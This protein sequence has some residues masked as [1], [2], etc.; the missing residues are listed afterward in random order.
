MPAFEKLFNEV[1]DTIPH[2]AE[3]ELKEFADEAGEIMRDYLEKAKADLRTY[4]LLLAAGKIS[5]TE[6]KSSVR[7][8]LQVG[9]MRLLEIKGLGEAAVD[10][11][12]TGLIN[13]FI[14]GA[15]KILI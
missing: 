7:G 14:D 13:T 8:K 10:G 9:E 11:F 12:V 2:L 5:E 3:T 1:K 6:F 4:S 15:I